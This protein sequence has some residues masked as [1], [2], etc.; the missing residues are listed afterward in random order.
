VILYL[1]LEF[2][3]VRRSWEISSSIL[4]WSAEDMGYWKEG[5]ANV[6]EKHYAED[7]MYKKVY[8]SKLAFKKRFTAFY[9]THDGKYAVEHG[10]AEA[11]YDPTK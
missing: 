3:E 5:T 7:P 6:H 9:S 4:P 8:D 1:F 2:G 10:M 11:A